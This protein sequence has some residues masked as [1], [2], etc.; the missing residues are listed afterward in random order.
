MQMKA[1][2]NPEADQAL[3]LQF[4]KLLNNLLDCYVTIKVLFVIFPNKAYS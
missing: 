2:C 3:S 4:I 1:K